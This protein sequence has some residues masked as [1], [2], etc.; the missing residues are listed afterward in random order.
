MVF[1]AI[2]A[3]FSFIPS[4]S[5]SSGFSFHL[6]EAFFGSSPWRHFLFFVGKERPLGW[7]VDVINE[8]FMYNW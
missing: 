5:F 2:C 6:I 3:L 1:Q 7:G 8:I 4:L